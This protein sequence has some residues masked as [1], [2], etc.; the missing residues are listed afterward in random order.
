M[1]TG[2]VKWFNN[3]KGFGFITPDEG[4]QDLFVH[5]SD[6]QMDG[7]RNL[8]QDQ[9]V[10]YVY[11]DGP[12]GPAAGQV[13]VTQDAPNTIAAPVEVLEEAMA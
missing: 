3:T 6:V 8:A 7:Y 5:Y 1:K 9:K 4:G 13:V 11:N 12:K 10:T 2:T